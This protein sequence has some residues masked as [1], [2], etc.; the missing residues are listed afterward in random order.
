MAH[1]EKIYIDRKGLGYSVMIRMMIIE[2][3]NK[4]E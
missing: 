3:A 4:K 2:K 1:S